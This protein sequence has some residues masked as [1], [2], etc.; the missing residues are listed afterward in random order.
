MSPSYS[1]LMNDELKEYGRKL[2]W[3]YEYRSME[4]FRNHENLKAG[5][6]VFRP[7]HEEETTRKRV[8]SVT[9]TVR[10][11]PAILELKRLVIGRID[12]QT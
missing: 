12:T 8:K 11:F 2:Q 5:Q 9:T 4:D 1:S 3:P 10:N 7:R 6:P